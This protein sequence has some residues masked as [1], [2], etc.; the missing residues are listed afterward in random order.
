ML[1]NINRQLQLCEV[2]QSVIQLFIYR[3]VIQCIYV[4]LLRCIV[5]YLVVNRQWHIM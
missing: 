5:M 1:S 4:D 3:N 2:M